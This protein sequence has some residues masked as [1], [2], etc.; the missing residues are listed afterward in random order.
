M[1]SRMTSATTATVYLGAVEV[2]LEWPS[3]DTRRDLCQGTIFDMSIETTDRERRLL[4]QGCT[5]E[6]ILHGKAGK[7]R[8]LGRRCVHSRPVQLSARFKDSALRSSH[9]L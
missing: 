7:C 3:H 8:L 6:P 1:I 5:F 4:M 2:C 9:H